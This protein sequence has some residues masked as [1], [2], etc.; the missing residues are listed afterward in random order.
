VDIME[1]GLSKWTHETKELT[2]KGLKY[3]ESYPVLCDCGGTYPIGGD[4]GGVASFVYT[5][6]FEWECRTCGRI[7]EPSTDDYEDN[8]QL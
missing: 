3:T 8:E 6:R 4:G 7:L 5:D 1:N 2:D